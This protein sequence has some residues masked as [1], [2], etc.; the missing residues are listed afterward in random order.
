MPEKI[1]KTQREA[2]VKF[3]DGL[4]RTSHDAQISLATLR[5]LQKKGLLKDVTRCNI[6]AIFS[7]RTTY[8]F[9][10]TTKGHENI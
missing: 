10:I 2:L 8:E 3:A 1:S 7:P 9:A 4:N 6:G 5:A